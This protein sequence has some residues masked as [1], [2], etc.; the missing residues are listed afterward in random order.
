MNDR[1]GTHPVRTERPGV[2]G[3][4]IPSSLEGTLPWSWAEQRL[5]EAET[6]WVATSRPDGRPHL[7]PLWAGWHTGRLWLEGGT[8]ARRARNLALN[9]AISVAVELARDGA[10]IVEGTCERWNGVSSDLEAGIARSFEKY[11]RPPRGYAVDPANWRS[12][13]GG[14][15]VVTPRVMLGWSRFPDDATRWVFET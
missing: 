9:P 2:R 13:D 11:A 6:Y 4:G 12:A 15:W 7:V 1:A 8:G 5:A 10:L 3:Y 14:I